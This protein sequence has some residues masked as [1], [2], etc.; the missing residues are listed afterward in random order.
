MS[1][2]KSDQTPPAEVSFQGLVQ[3]L[4]YALLPAS[5]W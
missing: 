1:L 3:G 5:H 2:E 4:Q